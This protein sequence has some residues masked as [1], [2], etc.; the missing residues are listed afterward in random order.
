MN[1]QSF[2]E[3]RYTKLSALTLGLALI[4][5]ILMKIIFF[6][7][8]FDKISQENQLM[9]FIS[10]LGSGLLVSTYLAQKVS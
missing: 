4:F 2:L 1:I 5:F 10:L 9:M 3:N 7:V 6:V 8:G